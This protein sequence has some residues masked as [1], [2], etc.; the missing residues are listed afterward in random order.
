MIGTAS[1]GKHRLLREL[2]ADEVVD[3]RSVDFSEVLSD[4]DVVL[5]SVGRGYAE[6]SLRV[7]RPG[8]LLV[9][10]VERTNAALA[11]RT[12]AEGRRFAG[13]TV[14]PDGAGLEAWLPSSTRGS[15]RSWS[16]RPGRSPRP[17]GHTRG[18]RRP[19]GSPES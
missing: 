18:S 11:A 6:R 2:G 17:P 9:T 7:L 5:E 1:A 10:I 3:H 16:S 15:S 12:V 14:E 8:G 13:V 19:R 4:I